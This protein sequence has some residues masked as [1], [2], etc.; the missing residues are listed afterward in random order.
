MKTKILSLISLLL[1]SV[2]YAQDYQ[3]DSWMYNTDG[4][5]ASYE[6]NNDPGPGTTVVNLTDSSDIKALYY[7]TTDI[8]V[9]CEGLASYQMGEWSIA[10]EP[11]AQGYTYN[12]PRTP[13]EETGTKAAVPSGGPIAFAVNGV[14]MYGYESAESWDGSGMSFTGNEIW[15]ADA[16]VNEGT[17]MDD[18]GG[19]HPTDMGSYHYH[20]TP[21]SLYDTSYTGSHSAIIG[22]APDG[23]PVY[24]PYGYS[25][26]LDDGSTVVRMESSY[27]TRSITQRHELPDGT[28]LGP[29]DW[30]PD[31]DATYTLGYF[32]EDYEYVYGLG[33]LDEYNGRWCVTPEYPSGTYAYFITTDGAGD[34]AFPYLLADEY[35]G[36]VAST[37]NIGY[38]TIPGGVTQ[39]DV[40]SSTSDVIIN[41]SPDNSTATSVTITFDIDTTETD[42]GDPPY[43]VTPDEVT[44]GGV[45][46]TSVSRDGTSGTITA[47]FDLSSLSDGT[48]TI[49]VT[50]N[51]P[52]GAPI[53]ITQEDAFTVTSGGGGSTACDDILISS[54]II[55]TDGQLADYNTDCCPVSGTNTYTAMTDSAGI[56][57]VWYTDDHVYI[58][59]TSLA[60]Y[61]M[62]PWATNLTPLA[63]DL[64]FK[65][66][67]V[68]TEDT[69]GDTET[70]S[71]GTIGVGV[72]GV[73]FYAETSSKSWDGSDNTG[74]GDGIWNTDAWVEE[75]YSMDD[76]GGGH[77]TGGGSGY[78]H[79]HATPFTLYDTTNTGVHSPIIGWALDG[80]PVYG[81]YGYSDSLDD[82]SAVVR[83]ESS[84]Q[85]RSITQ[86]HEL[87]DGT[88]LAPAQYGPDVDVTYPLGTYAEDNE[89]VYG[90]GHLDDH[91]GR[92]CV[93]PEY[94]SGTYA[95]FITVD[96]AGDPLYP[97]ILGPEYYGETQVG[98]GGYATIDA[99]AVQFDPESCTSSC[100][101]PDV[102]SLSAG[103]TTICEGGSTTLTASGNLNDADDWEWYEGSCGGTSV[104]TGS[105][106]SVS[107]VVTTTYYARGEGSCDGSTCASITI[108][109][110]AAP[111]VDAG[112]AQTICETDAVSLAGSS[113]NSSGV[114]WSGGTGSFAPNSASAT[115]T[116]TP[117]A[118]EITAGTVTLTLTATGN[119]SCASA[120]DD[121]TITI[122]GS[123]TVDAGSA[124]TIC[125]T[126]NASLSGSSNNSSGVTWSG[127]TGSFVPDNTSATST[128]TPS[129]AEITAGTVTLTLTATGNGSCSSV[130]D[131]VTITITGS[132]TTDAGSAQ[133]ICETETV[134]LSGSSTNSTGITW[135]GGTG[136]FSPDNTTATATYTPSAS[137]IT[138]GTV[139]LTLT[140]TG[141]GSCSAASDDVIITINA[142][143]TAS[144]GSDQTICETETVSLSGS[145]SNSTGITWSGG[146][147]VFSPDN[148]TA[149]ATYT[150]SASEIT[151]GT[152]TLTLTATGNG[153]CSSVSDDVTITIDAA[154]S[155]DAGSAQTICETDAVSLAGSSTNSSGVT[156]S[157]GTGSFAPD[158]TSA[159]ATYTPSA[160]EITAGTVTLTLTATGNGS[161]SSVS[162]DVTIT[163][164][165]SPTTDAG[166]AQTIC[167]TDAVSLAGSST[168]SSGVTWSGGMGS[169][170]PDN[171]SA[172]ATY[173]PS[174]AEIT[175]GTVTLTLTATGNGSCASASDDVTVNINELPT[176]TI[177][178]DASI[179]DDGS[180]T[181]DLTITMTGT[182]PFT[183]D[184]LRD[185]VTYG[186]YGP[187]TSPAT[188]SVSDDGTFTLDNLSDANCDAT[189][190]TGSATVSYSDE[191]IASTSLECDDVNPS[192][193]SD[194]FQI[195]V[196]VTQGDIGSVA[197]SELSAHGVVFT[198]QGAG[199]WLSDAVN[200]VNSVDLNVTDA[201]DCNGGLDF[202]S[203]THSCDCPTSATISIT[204]DNPVCDGNT[205]IVEVT[206]AGGTGPYNVTL[207]G[208]SGPSVQNSA[209]SPAT[210]TISDGGVYGAN[211]E[212]TG[213]ACTVSASGSAILSTA[214][215]P[216]VDAGADETICSS[217]N[218]T[219]TATGADSY[220]W[221]N[222]L[223][224]GATHTVSPTVTTTYIVTGTDVNGCVDTDDVVITVDACTAVSDAQLGDI[225]VYPN[226]TQGILYLKGLNG[227]YG[228]ELVNG[229]GV[230]VGSWSGQS[231]GGNVSVDLTGKIAGV[232][233]LVLTQDDEQQIL[234]IVKE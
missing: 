177:A 170:T 130:S 16:W 15:N 208:P 104:G 88:V 94:P 84:Y 116:Y 203:I 181:T 183:F 110:D 69:S 65:I 50:F 26:S 185:G 118:S 132:P 3:F 153:S 195:R 61:T 105:S 131:D 102:P 141:N 154:P 187:T 144:A 27:A 7:N 70:A 39:Y 54:F 80:V 75:G 28:V 172:T 108:T 126:D 71:S 127:G 173:T 220:T 231:N 57:S 191:I 124:Q 12:I 32:V 139:A 123:P 179:C 83:M 40:T 10:N 25:D 30:G 119:G 97:Y 73:A 159:T 34:P 36:T 87:P 137:E 232:Y 91:N 207:L 215:L 77:P 98:S 35:Y 115:A 103:S 117:S 6:K 151:A 20:A 169:F 168:N 163:I 160:A 129:A 210:F 162:D 21:Y 211:I 45:S 164:T 180:S 62:G 212:N 48:Y 157:G 112:L 78:Y 33:H 49:E 43:T 206:F 41:V 136:T 138:A 51:P 234:R 37:M 217:D 67:R 219:I 76:A 226:P 199:V 99:S 109:V 68:V 55:N 196:T 229:L 23:Y 5:L 197:I 140:T 9:T 111:T 161:C 175:A 188:V 31:V 213:D 72:D 74:A 2:I 122:T 79:Y 190:M 186:S 227:A 205:S 42:G 135:S 202:T 194:E 46:G 14:P 166:S 198:D 125:E 59:S 64:T 189:D 66:P 230:A 13:Q 224:A 86:R 143:P 228:I 101:E 222:S 120:S 128:Y 58:N 223:G 107:P 113:T 225:S 44:L 11:T 4:D 121:V 184:L 89:Y 155:V 53:V 200:E 158:N 148:T 81:P 149:T 63:Q 145:S 92:W 156:W 178:G 82:G 95:Y 100:T 29:G 8:Y 1:S 24:G 47:T 60:Y 38:S 90:S 93:T 147:G 221:D 209:T 152:V 201:N 165:G 204:G 96:A 52:M 85:L 146:S 176:G 142:G 17:T 56:Q 171:T 22:W 18:T 133:T 167:E 216:I 106:V 150:P 174:A 192:L 218:A 233:F 193:A 114:T 134:S 19:G 182:G 214:S